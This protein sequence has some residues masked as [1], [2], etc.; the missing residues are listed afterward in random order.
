MDPQKDL[1]VMSVEQNQKLMMKVMN[2]VVNIVCQ[3][4]KVVEKPKLSVI[5][6]KFSRL[7]SSSS[8]YSL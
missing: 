1:S 4:V 8:T 2:V 6:V 7:Q 5:V 3:N